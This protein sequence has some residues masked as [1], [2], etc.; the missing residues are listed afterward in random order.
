MNIDNLIPVLG[1]GARIEA[2]GYYYIVDG[3]PK[4]GEWAYHPLDGWVGKWTSGCPKA[5]FFSKIVETNDP[6]VIINMV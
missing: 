6:S 5:M 4:E 2:K 1:L 3:N